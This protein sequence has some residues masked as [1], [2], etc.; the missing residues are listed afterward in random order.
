LV[1]RKRSPIS[2]GV[3][4]QVNRVVPLSSAGIL[5]GFAEHEV[6]GVG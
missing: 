3:P 6:T 4:F 1:T 5:Q 2:F